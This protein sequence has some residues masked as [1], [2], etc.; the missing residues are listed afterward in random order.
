MLPICHGIPHIDGLRVGLRR[1]LFARASLRAR[2]EP[3]EY[4]ALGIPDAAG[5]GWAVER[6]PVAAQAKLAHRILVDLKYFG[7]FSAVERAAFGRVGELLAELVECHVV[8]HWWAPSDV[9]RETTQRGDG[10]PYQGNRAG[11]AVLRQITLRVF[12]KILSSH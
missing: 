9:P 7:Y 12:E 3:R 4:V 10:W 2:H 6:R 1:D 5:A 11:N 8:S